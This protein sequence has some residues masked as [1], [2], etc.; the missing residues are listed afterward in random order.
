MFKTLVRCHAPTPDLRP[1]SSLHP[2]G[3]TL[4][5]IPF[6]QV[7]WVTTNMHDAFLG[8]TTE[9]GLDLLRSWEKLPCL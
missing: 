4:L 7:I 5:E 1:P 2:Q 6:I 3:T 9:K 8:G